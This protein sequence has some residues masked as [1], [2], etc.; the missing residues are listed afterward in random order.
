MRQ[1]QL[2]STAE[3]AA[4]RN[5]P[6]SG[7]HSS[8]RDEFRRTHERHRAWGLARRHAER[9]RRARG[10]A[11]PRET[12]SR[13]AGQPQHP[14]PS[15]A[16]EAERVTVE[17]PSAGRPEAGQVT[18]E[19]ITPEQVTVEQVTPEQVTPEQ[20]TPEQVT[21]EQV[22]PEQVTVEQTS[23]E[24]APVQH[25]PARRATYPAAE[26]SPGAVRACWPKP[27]KRTGR[28]GRTGKAPPGCNDRRKWM[29][30]HRQSPVPRHG[31]R[32]RR[33]Q[34]SRA[35]PRP[36]RIPPEARCP[37]WPCRGSG[38]V[39]CRST[40]VPAD[41]QWSV[42][43]SAAAKP[44]LPRTA[45]KSMLDRLGPPTKDAVGNPD[46]ARRRSGLEDV[47]TAYP[48][49]RHGAVGVGDPV[50]R[51]DGVHPGRQLAGRGAGEQVG[52]PRPVGVCHHDGTR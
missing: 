1:L 18:P 37:G 10:C 48:A 15:P 50:Q 31:T 36:A 6:A 39:R 26:R 44:S 4:M 34:P 7:N 25:P 27:G 38:S 21:V 47:A 20:V 52:Q 3:V 30:S 41:P 13:R 40:P 29:H 42:A 24:Q 28:P 11:A 14:E 17:Q 46:A 35:G 49:L 9:L 33:Q 16:P 23:V 12:G 22:T 5:R 51:Q 19:Q 32:R 45:M 43:E 2:F 8:E